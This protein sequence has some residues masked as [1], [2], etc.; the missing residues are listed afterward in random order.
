MEDP[1][2]GGRSMLWRRIPLIRKSLVEGE[3][4]YV[5]RKPGRKGGDLSKG[6][7][8]SRLRSSHLFSRLLMK[9]L[10]G[11]ASRSLPRAGEWDCAR[12][13]PRVVA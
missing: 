8:W 13:R 1:C 11:A 9:F 5:R 6:Q 12:P 3:E 4:P 10:D 7:G 2:C